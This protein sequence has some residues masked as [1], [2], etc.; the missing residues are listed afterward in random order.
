MFP[1]QIGNRQLVDIEVEMVQT[2]C[3]FG[4]PFMEFKGERDTLE[5]WADNKGEEEIKT[6]WQE[7]NSKSL[8]GVDTGI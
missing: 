3:G 7:K 8:D 4:V 1:T 5:K 6:Y 2:S